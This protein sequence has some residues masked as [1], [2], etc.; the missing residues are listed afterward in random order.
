MQKINSKTIQK[1]G[2]IVLALALAGVAGYL[3]T[4]SLKKS[5]VQTIVEGEGE[6]K[7]LPVK[8]NKSTEA[9]TEAKKS[10]TNSKKTDKNAKAKKSTKITK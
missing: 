2:G 9:K 4:R 8:K 1:A 3:L 10:K 7:T 5:A 6:R